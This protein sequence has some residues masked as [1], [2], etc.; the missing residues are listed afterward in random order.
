MFVSLAVKH[1]GI[2]KKK[3]KKRI[4]KEKSII[5][6]WEEENLDIKRTSLI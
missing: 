1:N 3:T 4:L 5:K 6:F 2:A